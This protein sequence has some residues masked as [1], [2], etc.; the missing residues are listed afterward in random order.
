M[1][2]QNSLKK[3]TIGGLLWSFG[4]LMGNQGIQFIIQIILARMLMPED[5]G[6]IGMILV[7]VAIS[8]S[9]VDSGFTQA[10]IREQN[11]T[12]TDYSTVFYFNFVVS[13][14]I[15]FV[16]YLSAPAISNFFNQPELVSIL[17]VLSLG[18]IIKSF[19]I[20]PKAMFTKEVDFKTQAT[21]NMTASITS[22]VA[23]VALALAGF[24]V[25]S[26]V[27]RT[28][29]MNIVQSLLLLLS[30]KWLP[31]L[32]FSVASFKR[33]FGFGWKLLV[34]GLIDTTYNNI[35]FIII[36]KQYSASAL[37]Y[38][39]NASKFN[40]LAAQNLTATIQRVTYPVLSSIQDQQ[41]RLKQSFKKVIKLSAFIIFPIMVGL[42]A[43]GEPLILFVFGGQ[44]VEMIPYFQLLCLGGMLYPI[45]ALNLNIL[46][47]KGR[48]DL[49]LYL[50]IVKTIIPTI[51]IALVIWLELGVLGLVG[52]VV[53]DSYIALFINIFYSGREISYSVREQ[54]KDLIPIYLVT[55]AMGLV[56]LNAGEVFP[57]SLIIK[58]LLQIATGIVFYIGACKIVKIEE[59][60]T[61]YNLIIPVLRKM[62]PAKTN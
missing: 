21:V 12:Q 43:I 45:H 6:L 56:V 17:R 42:A 41:E 62:K 26:L 44:W 31:S 47:V 54:M 33:L 52:V 30:K 48:S 7:F 19:E 50:E 25:W 36:G 46:Q 55:M 37:G 29:A 27:I 51:L 10:L 35:F 53:A 13:I 1:N 39:T 49:F 59:L 15:Y 4:D 32:T 2:Q 11:A 34:S 14:F 3:K 40:D 28:L 18:V 57:D 8:N 24:G 5:F 60:K 58:M 16:L 38:Y 9:I 61:V 23:A 22:G 20:I